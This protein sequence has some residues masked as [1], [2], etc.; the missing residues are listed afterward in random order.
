M[1]WI[2]P[3]LLAPFLYAITTHIDKV[4]LSRY[5]SSHSVSALILLSAVAPLLLIPCWFFF[6]VKPFAVSHTTIYLMMAI[7]IIEMIALYPY[8]FALKDEDASF[9]APFF[10]TIPVFVYIFGKV[11]L[12]ESLSTLQLTGCLLITL[13]SA[14][15]SIDISKKQIHWKWKPVL[16]TLLSA[17]LYSTTAVLFRYQVMS[18]GR[19]YDL[20]FWQLLG[21]CLLGAVLLLF[22][23]VRSDFLRLMRSSAVTLNV[24]NE[25][26]GLGAYA[27]KRYAQVLVPAALA[28]SLSG[29]HP[30]FVLGITFFLQRCSAFRTE[31]FSTDSRIVLVQRVICCFGILIGSSL[32]V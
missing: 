11:F 29:A 20:L 4:L 15:L 7:G 19:Y 32:L 10:Q 22:S 12:N 16:L 31:N 25:L 24:I 1:Y 27:A 6:S 8:L 30:L 21:S 23:R 5:S 28:Q 2:G 3:A 26:L 18:E 13:F 9:V 14:L 17:L